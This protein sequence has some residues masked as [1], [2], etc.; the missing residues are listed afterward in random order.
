[1]CIFRGILKQLHCDI[2]LGEPPS[3]LAI[4]HIGVISMA[5]ALQRIA[6]MFSIL[7]SVADIILQQNVLT[8]KLHVKFSIA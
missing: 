5:L 4:E 6:H 8:I 7:D 3:A 1:M 2:S